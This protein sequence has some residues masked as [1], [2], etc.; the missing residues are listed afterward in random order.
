MRD[1]SKNPKFEK[2]QKMNTNTIQ[3]PACGKHSASFSR[4]YEANICRECFTVFG[5]GWKVL[6][7]SQKEIEEK[8]EYFEIMQTPFVPKMPCFFCGGNYHADELNSMVA[9]FDKNDRDGKLLTTLNSSVNA[10]EN[11]SPSWIHIKTCDDC[12]EDRKALETL[13]TLTQYNEYL[14]ELDKCFSLKS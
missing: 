10:S 6:G 11:D 5:Q 12:K 7:V 3:C 1:K 8:E 14:A 13:M 4:A 9:L 2:G